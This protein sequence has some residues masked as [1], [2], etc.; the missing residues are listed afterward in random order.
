VFKRDASGPEALRG[1]VLGCRH[2]DTVEY[3]VAASTRPVGSSVPLLYAPT[4]ELIRWARSVGATT[5]D[6]GGIASGTAGPGDARSGISDFKRY[7]SRN[8]VEVG[9]E[10]VFEPSRWRAA[11]AAAVSR[12]VAFVRRRPH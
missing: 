8:E 11:A 1:F 12:A 4:W 9:G 10:G 6:F 3:R 5:F 2:G 7:F